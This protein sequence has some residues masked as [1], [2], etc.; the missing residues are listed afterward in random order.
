MR[1]RWHSILILVGLLSAG[2]AAAQ[3]GFWNPEQALSAVPADALL[4]D[5]EKA[6]WI[7]VHQQPLINQV[8]DEVCLACHK[9]VLEP[10]VKARSPA[11]V[12]P[13][14]VLAWY[15]TLDTYEGEQDTFHRRHLLSPLAQELMNLRCNTCHQGNDL[16]EETAVPTA[17]PAEAGFAMRKMVDPETTCLKCHAPYN[18]QVMNLPG[19]WEQ[20]RDAVGNSCTACHAAFRTTRHQVNYLKAEA[21]EKAGAQNADVCYGCHGGRAWYRINYPYPRHAWPNMPPGTPE[22]AKDRPTESEAR[23]KK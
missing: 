17:S 10:S 16:R 20:T 23:F 14:E 22:W 18:Y 2:N 8:G 19:P 11:G 4:P 12:A 5:Y 21:I 13:S 3:T 15:Q 9:E 1:R 7:E 6:R